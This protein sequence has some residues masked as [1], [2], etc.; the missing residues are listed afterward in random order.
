MENIFQL[1]KYQ[2]KVM[3]QNEIVKAHLK[4]F[5]KITSWDAIKKY[6]ITRISARILELRKQGVKIK[7]ENKTN[8]GKHFAE[9]KLF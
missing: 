5:K 9:Y 2:G 8:K 3:T 6:R 4:S 7:T 1:K